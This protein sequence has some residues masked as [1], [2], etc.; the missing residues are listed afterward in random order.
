MQ[1]KDGVPVSE[2]D[3]QAHQNWWKLPGTHTHICSTLSSKLSEAQA[4]QALKQVDIQLLLLLY[5]FI[6]FLQSSSGH[7]LLTLPE[8]THTSALTPFASGSMCEHF[9]ATCRKSEHQLP[10]PARRC[11]PLAIRR[12]IGCS[13]RPRSGEKGAW[14][15]AGSGLQQLAAVSFKVLIPSLQLCRL[16]SLRLYVLHLHCVESSTAGRVTAG[17]YAIS[18]LPAAGQVCMHTMLLNSIL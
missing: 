13:I 3:K 11:R 16:P 14:E 7:T 17:L 12:G 5:G 1:R 18:D 6:S 4:L 2:A 15:L 8:Y 9:L 10:P